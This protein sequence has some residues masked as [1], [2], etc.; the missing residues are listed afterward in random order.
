MPALRCCWELKLVESL[1]R[2]KKLVA[3]A[4]FCAMVLPHVA[5]RAETAGIV[6]GSV[7]DDR[8][9]KPIAGVAVVA[10]SPS[11][12]YRTVTDALGRFRFLSVLPDTYSI[13][14]A[15]AGYAPY[16]TSLVVLNGSQQTVNVPL[17]HTLK[18]IASTHA[19]S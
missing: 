15:Y 6:S 4:G 11:A 8:T 3:L 19:R 17:S 5:A 12:T 2:F 1:L 9:H 10:K 16:S 18:T 14:F 13:S 7:T